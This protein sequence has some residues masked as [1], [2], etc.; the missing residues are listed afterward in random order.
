MAAIFFP[1]EGTR[2][3]YYNALEERAYKVRQIFKM[4]QHP[5][6]IF[7]ALE[8]ENPGW[9]VGQTISFRNANIA[10]SGQIWYIYRGQRTDGTKYYNLYVKPPNYSSISP[11][12]GG[13]VIAGAFSVKPAAVVIAP[14]KITTVAPKVIPEVTTILN[15]WVVPKVPAIVAAPEAALPASM[16]LRTVGIAFAVVLVVA[17]IVR[18][19]KK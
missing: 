11:A 9:R 15:K 13:E 16:N 4:S 5:K 8:G 12:K 7:I 6:T 18:G 19:A 2:F 1:T 10:F 14:T 3:D 17:L